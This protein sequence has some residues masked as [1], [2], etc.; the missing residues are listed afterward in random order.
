V[1]AT[2]QH[3][4][5]VGIIQKAESKGHWRKHKAKAEK[6]A[7]LREVGRPPTLKHIRQRLL[8]F[9]VPPGSKYSYLWI[10]SKKVDLNEGFKGSR[11][12]GF[13]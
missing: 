4:P 2:F 7:T 12:Q 6:S 5:P 1:A 8:F 10:I 11:G 3:P 9:D 13:E